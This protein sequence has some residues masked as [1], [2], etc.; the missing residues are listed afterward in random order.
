MDQPTDTPTVTP[1]VT[2]ASAV[3]PTASIARQ[4]RFAPCLLALLCFLLPFVKLSCVP[5]PNMK[6]SLSGK[7]FVFGGEVVTDPQQGKVEKLNPEPWAVAAFGLAGLGLLL[8]ITESHLAS[9]IVSGAGIVALLVFQMTF[10]NKVKIESRGA[11]VS[12]M[13][14]GMILA[15][16]LLLVGAVLGVYLAKRPQPEGKSVA[17]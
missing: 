14:V 15:M 3:T 11:V 17:R 6:R 8:A 16:I 1:A 5:D 7:E 13:D 9:G 2:P 4:L 12:E 10:A